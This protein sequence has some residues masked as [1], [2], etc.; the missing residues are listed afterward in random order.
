MSLLV[1][2]KGFTLTLSMIIPIGTQNAMMLKQSI[3]KQHHKKTAALFVLYDIILISLGVLGGS[4]L[5]SS[6][7]ALFDILTWGGIIFLVTYGALSMKSAL[8]KT[9][10]NND[11]VLNKKSAKVIFFTTLAVTFLNPHAYI[12]TVMVI[13]SVGG[14]YADDIKIYF[15]LGCIL[16][17]MTWFSVLTFGATKLSKQL[18]IPKVKMSIDIVIAIIMWVIAWS[19]YATWVAR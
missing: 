11:T 14:Q 1:L 15:L 10:N 4:I 16:G 3:N 2:A 7:D 18:T 5:L 12:D 8:L 9:A 13:G 17:S 6:S 19:L